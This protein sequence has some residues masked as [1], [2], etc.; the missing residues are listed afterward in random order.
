MVNNYSR[1]TSNPCDLGY[2]RIVY[3]DLFDGIKKLYKKQKNEIFEVYVGGYL[4]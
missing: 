2:L 3:K 1:L 4:E